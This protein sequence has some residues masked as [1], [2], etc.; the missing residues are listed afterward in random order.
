MYLYNCKY[1][2]IDFATSLWY[3]YTQKWTGLYYSR[4]PINE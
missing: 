2:K 3:I 1:V 4:V